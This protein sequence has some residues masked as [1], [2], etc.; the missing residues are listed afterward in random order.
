VKNHY[1]AQI[2]AAQPNPSQS[3]QIS[4]SV[5]QILIGSAVLVGGATIGVVKWFVSR[6]IRQYEDTNKELKTEI[7]NLKK[8]IKGLEDTLHNHQRTADFRA[9]EI[10]RRFIEL[11]NK[12]VDR[13]DYL[14]HQTTSDLKLD[15]LHK[16]LDE[17]MAI[18][19]RGKSS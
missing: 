5:E 13:E 8:E 2:A 6:S 4:I 9:A 10:D 17:I 1:I 18:I 3:G 19:L 7:S 11:S 15:S 14:K 16:R 12:Y